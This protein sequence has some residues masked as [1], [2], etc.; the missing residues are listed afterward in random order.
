MT[1]PDVE[2]E[3]LVCDGFHVESDGRYR[4]DDLANL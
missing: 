1:Y 2:V 4:G 3:V